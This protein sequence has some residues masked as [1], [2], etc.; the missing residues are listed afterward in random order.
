MP[1]MSVASRTACTSWGVSWTL[2]RDMG[3]SASSSYRYTLP[4]IPGLGQRLST[5]AQGDDRRS[6]ASLVGLAG[7]QVRDPGVGPQVLA[8]RLAQAPG[9]VAVDHPH[10]PARGEERL[11]EVGVERLQ[12]RLDPLADE[13]DLGRR[14]GGPD[15]RLD[16]RS[17]PPRRP[18]AL[19]L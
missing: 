8:H 6:V 1:T 11:V 10:L 4:Q 17:T 18:F 15:I 19:P 3:R 14:L 12:G 5:P 13:V 9:A 2:P 7:A 16:P